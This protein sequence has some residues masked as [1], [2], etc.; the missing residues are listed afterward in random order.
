MN[1]ELRPF[2]SENQDFLFQLYASTRIHEIAPFGWSPPQQEAFL[3]VQFNAQQGWY[4]QAYPQAD[5]QIIF[6]ED[7]PIGRILVAQEEDGTRLVDIA[8]LPEYRGRGIG[9]Q[10]YGITASDPRWPSHWVRPESSPTLVRFVETRFDEN[11]TT[12][13]I[14]SLFGDARQVSIHPMPLRSIF[15]TLTRS[16]AQVA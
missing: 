3:R 2:S 10:L 7:Q 5:H 8:L 15:V 9:T 1:V 16:A 6:A 14:R 13:E 4:Q 12:D 11:R